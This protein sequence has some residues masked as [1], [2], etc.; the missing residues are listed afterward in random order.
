MLRALPYRSGPS[1]SARTNRRRRLTRKLL[2]NE[3]GRRNP[4]TVLKPPLSRFGVPRLSQHF[5]V[6]RLPQHSRALAVISETNIHV[7][8]SEW[9]LLCWYRLSN[10]PRPEKSAGGFLNRLC[11]DSKCRGFRNISV[12]SDFRSIH[13]LLRLFHG[14]IYLR[15]YHSGDCCVGVIFL[16]NPARRNPLA[17]FCVKAETGRHFLPP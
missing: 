5:C 10:E 14:Q 12:Y 17:G 8:L 6:Q 11:R 9:R 16:T 13:G 15:N 2:S 3:P 1:K 4:P 7:E